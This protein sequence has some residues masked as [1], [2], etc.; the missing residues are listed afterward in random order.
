MFLHNDRILS[1][2]HRNTD[3]WDS[4]VVGTI[5]D[6]LMA[7]LPQKINSTCLCHSVRTFGSWFI[8][9]IPTKVR[10]FRQNGKEPKSLWEN[11]RCCKKTANKLAWN[12]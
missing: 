9:R 8:I 7:V 4:R 12:I 6:L 5:F 3:M 1:A 11:M 2:F 10:P